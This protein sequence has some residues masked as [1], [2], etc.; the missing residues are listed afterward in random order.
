MKLSHPSPSLHFMIRCSHWVQ[1][2][3][4]TAYTE[5]SIHPVQHT[6]S[7][8]YTQYSIHPVQH[9]PSTAYTQ[10]S[11]HPVQHT[12]S[13]AYTQH[14]IHPVQHTPSTP[15]TE[16]TIHRVHHTPSTPYTE[17][18]IHRV[19]NTPST[20]YI[21]YRIHWVL[22]T[23]SNADNVCCINP[24]YTV[25]CSKPVSLFSADLVELNS[26]HSCTVE[27]T[28]D[29]SLSFNRTCLPVYCLLIHFVQIYC[30]Q[31]DFLQII[32]LQIDCLQ[33]NCLQIH[34]LQFCSN[35]AWSWP[36]CFSPNMLNDSFQAHFGVHSILASKCISKLTEAQP[37]S[38]SPSSLDLSAS[39][40]ISN[41]AW[42][43]PS[44]ASQ[45]LLDFSLQ[46]H[47]LTP[48]ITA[49]KYSFKE[50]QQLYGDTGV[51]EMAWVKES[52]HLAY[53]RADRHHFTSMSSYHTMKIHTVF[54]QTFGHTSL[55]LR[56]LESTHMCGFSTSGSIVSCEPISA[57]LEPE[58]LSR[59][60]SV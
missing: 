47:L 6:P 35:L 31:F 41:F 27:L 36:P 54:F 21:E 26:Q 55:C 32:R 45:I 13:T 17:Y 28:H 12:P 15:Y 10:H 34:C 4:S 9:T 48:S 2:T 3:L 53:P 11:I 60:N 57:L 39:K 40:C 56:L 33:I 46:V 23:P 1:H 16:Y 22:H 37:P 19:H 38:V 51:T 58:L 29:Q 43:R 5:Y 20:P 42:L 25:S 44:S 49:S 8:A 7:T 24:W 50:R 18:T 14:S 30:L 52:I 59:T